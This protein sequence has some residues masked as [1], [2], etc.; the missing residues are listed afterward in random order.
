M[1]AQ[2]DVVS[3]AAPHQRCAPLAGP[4]VSCVMGAI[5]DDGG[6]RIFD[7]NPSRDRRS[8]PPEL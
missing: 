6:P 2:N 8:G 4:G 3:R 7:C 1:T 5:T